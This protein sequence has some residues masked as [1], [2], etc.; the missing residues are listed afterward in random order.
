MHFLGSSGCLFLTILDFFFFFGFLCAHTSDYHFNSFQHFVLGILFLSTCSFWAMFTA[1]ISVSVLMLYLPRT[2]ACVSNLFCYSFQL[3]NNLYLTTNFTN[4]CYNI[5][6]VIT[7]TY[8]THKQHPQDPN[9][10]FCPRSAPLFPLAQEVHDP[11]A[12]CSQQ[13][14]ALDKQLVTELSILQFPYLPITTPTTG[15]GCN[16][17][18][19]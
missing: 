17:F 8:V 6:S 7:S 18:L 19:P 13:L 4:L 1:S 16:H 11:P 2:L 10:F 5:Y 9:A 15:P 3:L 12:P 14:V